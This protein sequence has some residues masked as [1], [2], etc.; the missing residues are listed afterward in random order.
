MAILQHISNERASNAKHS[1]SVQ[2]GKA[3]ATDDVTTDILLHPCTN[4]LLTTKIH[5]NL[6]QK[7]MQTRTKADAKA[8]RGLIPG[9]RI[10]AN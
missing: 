7:P 5:F 4:H 3:T 1:E 8:T 2:C 9:F 10:M 6:P